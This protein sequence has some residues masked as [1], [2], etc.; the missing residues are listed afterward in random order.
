MGRWEGGW[1]W[2]WGGGRWEGGGGRWEGGKLGVGGRWEGGWEVNG[3]K[4]S[5]EAG[6]RR[7]GVGGEG[8]RQWHPHGRAWG[9]FWGIRAQGHASHAVGLS[10]TCICH[11][12][13]SRKLTWKPQKGPYEDYSPSKRGL[14]GIPC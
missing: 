5:W 14:Y 1:E 9:I 4:G 8:G 10:G 13:H 7:E 2:E 3:E 12:L 11:A 6:R